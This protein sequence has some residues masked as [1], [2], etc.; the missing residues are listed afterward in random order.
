MN[1]IK[2][3]LQKIRALA[4]STSFEHEKESALNMLN[5]LMKKHGITEGE[6][7]DEAVSMRDFKFRGKREEALLMQISFTVLNTMKFKASYSCHRGMR[8]ADALSVECT[9]SQKLEIEFLFNFYRKLYQQEEKRLFSAFLHKHSL[10]PDIDEA[11]ATPTAA[12]T[13]ELLRLAAMMQGM[14]Y[15]SPQRRLTAKDGE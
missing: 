3:K 13:E 8:V 2:S 7:D 10:F 9:V 6:L 11:Y 5:K 1:D 14:E 12:D 4:E 15:K